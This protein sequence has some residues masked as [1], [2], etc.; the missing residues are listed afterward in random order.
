[1]DPVVRGS[2]LGFA[3]GDIEFA[4]ANL[5]VGTVQMHTCKLRKFV[6]YAQPS[7]HQPQL[8]AARILYCGTK[9]SELNTLVCQYLFVLTSGLDSFCFSSQSMC[10]WVK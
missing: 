7:F 2:R 9:N 10:F 8:Y 5:E 4:I 6:S 1:M 3:Y